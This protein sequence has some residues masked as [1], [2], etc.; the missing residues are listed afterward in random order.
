MKIRLFVF[1]LFALV[2]V[3]TSAAKRPNIIFVLTDDQ[4]DNTFGAMGHPFVKTP[5][6]DRLLSQSVRFRNTYI[7]EPVCAPSR[8]S[9]LT[10]MH[11]RVHGIGF[12][13]SYQLTEDQWS[14]SY[15]ALVKKAGYYTGFVGKF[16]VEYYSFRGKAGEKFDYWWGHDGWTKFLP[17][18]TKSDSTLPYHK[19]KA[20]VIT[21]IM[22]EAMAAF[23]GAIPDD[24]PFC[25]SVSLNTPHGSQTTSMHQEYAD[26]R[27][28][29]RPANENPEL[30]GTKFYDTLYR[31]LDIQIPETTGKDP[32]RFIPKFIQDQDKGRRTQTYQ[33]SYTRPTCTE[34]HIRYYQTIS[35]ID[36]AIGGLLKELKDRG[37]ADNTVI[38]YGSDHGLLM[39]EYGMGGKA[40]LYDL[41]SKIPCFV[42]DPRAPRKQRGKELDELVSSLD[43]TKT[44]LDY[45]DVEAPDF[46]TGRSLRSL[47]EGKKT[48]WRNELF[49]E[50]LYTGR[51]TPFQEGMRRGKWKY[52]RMFDGVG[53]YREEH[54]DFSDREPDFEMLFDLEKD[55]DEMN[56]LAKSHAGK[57]HEIFNL[58]RKKTAAESRQLNR[59]R[60]RFAATVEIE[61]RQ[62]KKKK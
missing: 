34:H 40:L 8:V 30:K 44:I 61:D 25:L 52:I 7:A 54:V 29:T 24:Q 27:K 48:K 6:V 20:E 35:G 55:P 39:G 18:N 60:K 42:H 15:P 31:D 12:T 38:I 2:F 36:H 28:M 58:L 16:G 22:S 21:E 50:S 10:G 51:D 45:A 4:R 49:L 62:K 32:Y 23:F 26:W 41:S 9:L 33:Y 3:E 13:S 17:K 46:M 19:A 1:F 57:S 37:L 14:R 56:N 59:E 11:E 47:V 5:N 43:L 53:S